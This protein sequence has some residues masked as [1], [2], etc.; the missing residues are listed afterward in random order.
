MKAGAYFAAI[1]AVPFA[2]LA[3]SGGAVLWDPSSANAQNRV[4][5]G[6]G[7]PRFSRRSRYVR[8]RHRRRRSRARQSRRN[9][10]R[11]KKSK[12][13]KTIAL[14]KRDRESGPIQI[15]ISL[16]K[17]TMTVYEANKAVGTTRVSTG[18]DGFETP[19]GIFGIIH[20]R[21]RHFSNIYNRAPMPFMQRLTWS[22]IALHQGVVPNYRASHGCIRMPTG[23][24]R[25]LFQFT[26]RRSHV[27]IVD[28]NPKPAPISHPA[29]FQPTTLM[30]KPDLMRSQVRPVGIRVAMRTTSESRSDAMV[31]AIPSKATNSTAP[32]R[33]AESASAATS[34][35]QPA[36]D[37][38]Q[39]DNTELQA[40]RRLIHKTRSQAPLRILITRRSGR[41]RV[42]Q[43]QRLLIQLGFDPGEPDGLVGKQT[44]KAIKAFQ[45]AQG[46]AVTGYPNPQFYASLREA[47]GQTDETTAF[48]HVRQHQKDIYSAPIQL[49]DP[50]KPLGAQLFTVVEFDPDNKAIWSGITVKSRRN[51][52]DQQPSKA[53]GDE[54]AADEPVTLSDAL[55]QIVIPDHVR[56]RIEDLLTPGSSLIVTDG[57]HTRET[58]IDTDFIV[59]TR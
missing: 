57:G 17:Q 21:R 43:A 52:A 8:S 23:F 48:I 20:K 59:L 55:D 58:G 31:L 14:P 54:T 19:K 7:G 42:L 56:L 13:H 39:V 25:Q 53:D 46:L 33:T 1:L 9:S 44:V 24:A 41:D 32:V 37:L 51:G 36:S 34:Q 38:F 4:S 15:V 5:W 3:M 30:P 35:A 50:S 2:F 28:G 40:H 22:G 26:E 16:G 27:V 10:W 29:L 11:S 12:A 49:R 45:T 18:Q 47:S 6:G